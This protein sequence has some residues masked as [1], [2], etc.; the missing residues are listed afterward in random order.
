MQSGK[1]SLKR[2]EDSLDNLILKRKSITPLRW[3]DALA[4][5]ASMFVKQMEGCS[6]YANQR[7]KDGHEDD[8]L[9]KVASFTEHKRFAIYPDKIRWTD[10]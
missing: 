1:N 5:S 7:W 10:S 9:K 6:I 3:S 2:F 8:H 4:Y